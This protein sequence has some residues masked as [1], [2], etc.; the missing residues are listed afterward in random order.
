MSVMGTMHGPQQWGARV[1]VEG[2]T[3]SWDGSSVWV[4]KPL[5]K[6]TGVVW[7]LAQEGDGN[8]HSWLLGSLRFV[9]QTACDP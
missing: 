1:G 3:Q 2:L 8:I 6:S 7:L 9:W 4:L 5:R